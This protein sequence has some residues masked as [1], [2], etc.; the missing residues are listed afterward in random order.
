MYVVTFINEKGGVGK[1]SVCF[2]TAWELSNRGK[3]I[4]LIDL[5]GQKANISFFTGAYK[6]DNLTMSD[7][8]KHNTDINSAILSVKKN[9]DITP[10]NIS[11]ASLNIM[12]AKVSKFR[13]SLNS[14]HNNYD[15]IFIDVNPAPAWSHYLSLSVSNFALIV[16]LPDIASLEGN[17]AILDTISE[18]QLTTNSDLQILGFLINKYDSRTTLSKRVIETTE[19]LASSVQSRVFN[20]SIRQSVLLSENILEHEGITN[21]APKSLPALLYSRFATEFLEAVENLT[22]ENKTI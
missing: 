16:M 10:A 8:F 6:D 22:E 21:Y 7:V 14:I 12:D 20:N 1:S 11:V 13:S 15:F 19:N 2:N 17:K 18:I 9:L 5:D 4:L 3:N